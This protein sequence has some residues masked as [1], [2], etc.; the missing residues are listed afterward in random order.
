MDVASMTVGGDNLTPKG[1]F[2][3]FD[4]SSV[5]AFVVSGQVKG[6]IV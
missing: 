2:E 4:T 1:L 3:K 5:S 6:T